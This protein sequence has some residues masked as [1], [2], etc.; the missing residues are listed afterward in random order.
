M[1]DQL[2]RYD[3]CI[4]GAGV[5]GSTIAACLG[6][7]GKSV[8][9][10]EQDWSEP[11]EIIGEL[12]Q[13]DGAIRLFQMG[14]DD[15]FEGYDAQEIHGY[16]MFMGG[17][18]IRVPYPSGGS[19]YGFRYGRFVQKL[20][21]YSDDLENI[22]KFAGRV[23]DLLNGEA[24]VEGVIYRSENGEQVE[25]KAH[26]VILCQGSSSKLRKGLSSADL[27][28][29]GYMTG[30]VLEGVDAP[31]ANHGHV[32]IADPAPVLVYPVGSEKLRVL[33]DFPKEIRIRKGE[34]LN[35]HLVEKIAPQLPE[36]IREP[37]LVR[38][39]QG[40]FKSKPTCLLAAK[41]VVKQNVVLLGDSLNQRHPTTGGGMTVALTDV[42][43]LTDSLENIDPSDHKQLKVAIKSFYSK[44]YKE[45]AT[46][47]ILAYA[48]Y[49]VFR[50][51][52][53]GRACFNYLKRGGKFAAEPMAILAGMS[54]N[55]SMLV[56][57]FFKVAL[58]AAKEALRPFPTPARI[59]K[60]SR[61]MRDAVAILAPL[62]RDEVP[63][64][65]EES[66]DTSKQVTYK[67]S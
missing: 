15:V 40:G 8:A 67:Y 58:F 22:H 35:R 21:S 13:P 47:N 31:F 26:L 6:R 61:L 27:K 16:A 23:V 7:Q 24:G 56:R 18:H 57:H 32:I 11:D 10:I 2:D 63:S 1:S 48:L 37:F 59:A 38:V 20:R 49:S 25:L 65:A 28:V 14:F 51:P 39:A 3:I 12:L 42:Q 34:E 66:A 45:N 30:F 46:I 4:V 19:G 43:A 50:H 5:A 55:R 44:R 17:D 62:I 33:I 36:S 29:K 64:V 60:A 41:P 54:R 53:L 52:Q 9:V